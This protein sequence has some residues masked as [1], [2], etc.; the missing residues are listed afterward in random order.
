MKKANGILIYNM[1]KPHSVQVIQ[2]P[3]TLSKIHYSDYQLVIIPGDPLCRCQVPQQPVFTP[4]PGYPRRYMLMLTGSVDRTEQGGST[5]SK[6]S[7][8]REESKPQSRLGPPIKNSIN[9]GNF[10]L[11]ISKIR[12][13]L[14]VLL[15]ILLALKFEI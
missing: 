9:F 6:N 5:G 1:W 10:S 4:I 14:G 2:F 7:A 8:S 3:M 15:S 13:L 12:E 11:F